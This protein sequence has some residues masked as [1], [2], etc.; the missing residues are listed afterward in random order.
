MKGLD[1]KVRCPSLEHTVSDY[2]NLRGRIQVVSDFSSKLGLPKIETVESIDANHMQ[3]AR[4]KDRSDESYRFIAGVLKQFLK[5][6]NP[7]TNLPVRPA[8]HTQRATF[9]EAY[10]VE[11]R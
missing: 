5:N 1:G 6:T 8:T 4:C 3:I 10:E 2:T 7:D 11:A 9:T